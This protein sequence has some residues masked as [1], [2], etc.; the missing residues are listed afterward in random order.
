MFWFS[1]HIKENTDK[2]CTS[3]QVTKSL[4]APRVLLHGLTLTFDLCWIRKVSPYYQKLDERS[5]GPALSSLRLLSGFTLRQLLSLK[6]AG[7]PSRRWC[8]YMCVLYVCVWTAPECV[9]QPGKAPS[10]ELVLLVNHILLSSHNHAQT[11][12]STAGQGSTQKHTAFITE[13]KNL[14]L[15]SFSHYIK[16]FFW[17]AS[18]IIQ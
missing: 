13:Q 1:V 15:I 6:P 9:L 2:W 12:S 5:A 3:E 10:S 18:Y 7:R 11:H 16:I 14:L 8:V 4:P 17:L